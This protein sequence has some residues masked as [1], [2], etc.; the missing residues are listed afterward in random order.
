MIILNEASS[1]M[2]EWG[3]IFNAKSLPLCQGFSCNGA[4]METFIAR[5]FVTRALLSLWNDLTAFLFGNDGHAG[6][7]IDRGI[8]NLKF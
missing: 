5:V 1:W 8:K 7:K 2:N 3:N 6:N 4:S